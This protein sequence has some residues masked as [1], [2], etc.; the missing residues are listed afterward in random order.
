MKR[1]L[2]TIAAAL[3][4]VP[5]LGAQE[6]TW[7]NT[8]PELKPEVFELLN[9]NA[10][11]LASVKAA[12]QSGDDNAAAAA[13]VFKTVADPFVGKLSYFKVISG[14]VSPELPLVNMR[15]GETERIN[16]VMI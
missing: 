2:I 3:A 15:T 12:H 16:K 14:K 11:G 13:L 1:I 5:T 4:L 6:S 7:K 8:E 10:P 9:L